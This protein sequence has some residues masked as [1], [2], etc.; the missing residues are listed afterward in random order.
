MFGLDDMLIGTL[1]SGAISYMGQE[2]TNDT[3]RQIAQDNSAF[4]AAE[5]EKARLFNAQQAAEN[6]Q[7]QAVTTDVNRDWM[8]MMSGTS[9]QRAI[10]DMQAAGL[11]PMLAY[12]QGGA[13][14]PGSSAPSGSAASGPSASAAANPIIGNKNL[15]AVQGA[16]S[17]ASLQQSV[18]QTRNIESQTAVNQVEARLKEQDIQKSISSSGHLDAQRD[19]IRQEM[20][21]FE[22]RMEKLGYETFKAKGERELPYYDIARAERE[23]Q[24][25]YPLQ[26]EHIERARE[27]KN[28]AELLGLEVPKAI[29][30]A[31]FEQSSFG[32]ARP[33][34][35]HG[36]AN[37]G[38]LVGSAAQ[39]KRA[40]SPAS[41][42]FRNR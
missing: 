17:A 36:T 6:R 27:L 22:K 31:A 26:Q 30:D 11:N 24:R 41:Q 14:T 2:D 40:F 33:Y 1:V 12:S 34:A 5:A 37:L 7:F 25:D 23:R 4:N 10:Q 13:S 8:K 39:A 20:Q 16:A 28:R 19:N 9:Y 29:N 3:N 42:T 15:A 21:S 18:A 35:E 38:R 32:A